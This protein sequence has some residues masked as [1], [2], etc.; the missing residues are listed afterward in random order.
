MITT[1]DSYGVPYFFKD[2]G[3]N[4]RNWRCVDLSPLS[5][6]FFINYVCTDDGARVGMQKIVESVNDL[7]QICSDI[8]ACPTMKLTQVALLTPSWLNKTKRSD[9]VDIAKIRNVELDGDHPQVTVFVTNDGTELI[10]SY[11]P[12]D[13]QKAKNSKTIFVTNL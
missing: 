7:I 12:V 13:F 11:G 9:L 5:P 10:D 6:Y 3:R 2:G 8:Q 4:I 1:E